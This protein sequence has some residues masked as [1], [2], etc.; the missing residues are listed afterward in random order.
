MSC[1][2]STF[3]IVAFSLQ[4]RFALKYEVASCC[5]RASS[6]H[7]FWRLNLPGSSFSALF[8][9]RFQNGAKEPLCRSRR[10]LSMTLFLNLLFEQIANS[11]EYLLAKFG[12]DKAANEPYNITD[13]SAVADREIEATEG[14]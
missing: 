13:P 2:Y 10:E 14:A 6:G 11:N 4:P 1:P 9:Y 8:D 5:S 12:I 3:I 7:L